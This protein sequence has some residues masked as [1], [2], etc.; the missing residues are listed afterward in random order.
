MSRLHGVPG[1][2]M[3]RIDKLTVRETQ[4]WLNK[5]PGN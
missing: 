1:I 5:L 3:K 2:G 4:T